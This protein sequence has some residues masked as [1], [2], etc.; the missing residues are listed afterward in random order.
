MSG[1][2]ISYRRED[3]AGHAG[4]LFDQLAARLGP[5]NVF[6]DV[7]AIRPGEDFTRAIDERIARCDVMIVMIGKGWLD[8][9]SADGRRR[10]DDADD[11]VRREIIAGL[12]RS[13]VVIPVLVAGASM[14][15]A[16]QLPPELAVLASR[17]AMA[18]FDARFEVDAQSLLEA[19]ERYLVSP[20]APVV[21]GG[22]GRRRWGGIGAALFG[23]G[24]LLGLLW[25]NYPGRLQHAPSLHPSAAMDLSGKWI[26]KVPVDAQRSYTLRLNL[27]AMND[28]LLG[29]IDF[30]TGSG[31]LRDGRVD[32]DRV[33]FITVHQPQFES[34]DVTTRF[35]G[36]VVGEEL[37][38]VMQY[39]DVTKR[40]RLRREP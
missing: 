8:C 4:R 3:S 34:G 35:E 11:F 10:L 31:G 23:G 22:P 39:N 1:V 19:V 24:L 13:L 20:I 17:Q 25:V 6:M 30:P 27:Q 12:R 9:K 28:Q 38:L 14:P 18:I 2:F 33:S 15:S 37:D 36:R 26:A 7:D 40:I 16:A 29:S 21:A 5:H 32:S